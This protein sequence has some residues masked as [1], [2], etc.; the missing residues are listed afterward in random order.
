ME[1]F[2]MAKRDVCIA[3]RQTTNT[4]LQ[5]LTLLN[6]PRFLQGCRALAEKAL[7]AGPDLPQ[8]LQ[9]IYRSLTSEVPNAAELHILK[10]LFA[11]QLAAF[12][13]ENN[14]V[15]FLAAT[16]NDVNSALPAPDLA[17]MTMVASAMMNFDSFIMKR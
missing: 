1:I 8:R 4:P 2:D 14:A 13:A 9:F 6:E 11:E 17:A 3:R 16:G 5:A 12:Q 15:S 10:Q 7:A